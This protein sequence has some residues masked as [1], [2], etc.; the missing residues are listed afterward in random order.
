MKYRVSLLMEAYN[1]EQNALT[2][3]CPVVA[4]LLQQDF[5]LDQVE[6]VLLGSPEQLEPW[7]TIPPEWNKFGR[8]RLAPMP[9]AESHYWEQKNFGANVA[10]SDIIAF[11]DSD[12]IPEPTW[13]SA[14][15]SGIESGADASVGPSMYQ[16]EGHGPHSPLMLAAASISWGFVLSR[17]S[18]PGHPMA[19]S[20]LGHNCGIRRETALRIPMR[21]DRGSFQSSVFYFDLVQHN[22]K[23]VYQPEQRAAHGINLVW[24]LSRRH[25]RTGWESY[26]S[27]KSHPLWPRLRWLEKL[28]WIEPIVMRGGM[29]PRDTLHW[30][31]YRRV[32]GVGAAQAWLMLPL[33]VVT[34]AAARISE[35]AGM[36]GRLFF[37]EATRHQARF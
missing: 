30:F 33:I 15:V 2:D 9:S 11:I 28:P 29:V 34:S 22:A 17:S 31:R 16:C 24:W 4:A 5:P 37:P 23:V 3:R 7:Q 35:M 1:E 6:F 25:F 27:R 18:R 32:V 19:A 12:A 10:D 8:V 13:L 26:D 20:L 14:L 36:Y 21:T